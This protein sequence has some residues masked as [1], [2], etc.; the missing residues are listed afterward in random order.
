[1]TDSSGFAD[2]VAV[3]TGAAGFIGRAIVLALVKRGAKVV[4][5]DRMAADRT[6][7]AVASAGGVASGTICDI[8]DSA[9]VDRAIAS[10]LQLHGRIDL[11]V[12]CAGGGQRI[13]FVETTDVEW[14]TQINANLSGAFFTMRAVLP[15]M[16]ER[17]SGAIVNVAS[18]SGVIGGLPSK[19]DQGRSGPAY[20][21][22]KAGLIGLTKWAAREFGKHG[23]R[24]NAIAPGPVLTSAVMHGYDYGVDEYP[25][26]RMGTP[27]DM[28]EAVV[29]L[30]SPAAGFVTGEVLKVSGGVGM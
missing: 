26:P 23:I 9:A 10:A 29:Y 11:L 4:I 8:A 14:F 7:A 6:L 12:N 19:G 24:V 28:A 2:K 16:L 27:E 15:D 18:I 30:A 3:V 21:A 5:L 1:M 20:G 22:A 17:R 25:I 13:G